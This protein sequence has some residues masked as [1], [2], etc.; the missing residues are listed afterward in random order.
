MSKDGKVLL[1]CDDMPSEEGMV[2]MQRVMEM[3]ASL[4]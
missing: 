4:N 2:S 1:I 3:L